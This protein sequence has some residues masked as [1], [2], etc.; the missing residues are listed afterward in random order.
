MA[1]I[2]ILYI[3]ACDCLW[4]KEEL[5]KQSKKAILCPY[6]KKKL[7]GRVF[8]CMDCKTLIHTSS[9][10][11]APV[12]CSDCKKIYKRLHRIS[13]KVLPI[14]KLKRDPSCS[15]YNDCLQKAGKKNKTFSCLN[16]NRFDPKLIRELLETENS[17]SSAGIDYSNTC[18]IKTDLEI[19]K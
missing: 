5:P 4:S 9:K 10:G 3:F 14:S 16:C 19:L 13:E 12:R 17:L 8:R 15:H 6:H 18:S 1:I 2:P 7:I 11:R